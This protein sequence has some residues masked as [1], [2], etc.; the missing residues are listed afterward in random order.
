[1]R[2]LARLVCTRPKNWACFAEG[3]CGGISGP[4]KFAPE[5]EQ[6]LGVF[7]SAHTQ[8]FLVQRCL[9]QTSPMITHP[10]ITKS[11]KN[12]TPVLKDTQSDWV[13]KADSKADSYSANVDIHGLK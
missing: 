1:M 10:Q 9:G 13:D 12:H 5:T 7:A 2:V 3:C 11:Q 6:I 4:K 8:T